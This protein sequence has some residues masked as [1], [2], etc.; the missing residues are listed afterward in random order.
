MDELKSIVSPSQGTQPSVHLISDFIDVDR[1]TKSPHTA[2]PEKATSGS[3]DINNP[4]IKFPDGS[5][6][7]LIKKGTYLSMINN[8]LSETMEFFLADLGTSKTK[9]PVVVSSF[10]DETSLKEGQEYTFEASL[11]QG[12]YN[13]MCE[14]PRKAGIGNPEGILEKT[15]TDS[16]YYVRNSSMRGY[17]YGPP[18]ETV[19]MV[20]ADRHSGVLTGDEWD[21]EN[22]EFK[23]AFVNLGQYED[24]LA[25]NLQDPA[26]HAYTPP[27]F[28]GKSSVVYRVTPTDVTSYTT[29]ELVQKLTNPGADAVNRTFFVDEYTLPASGSNSTHRFIVDEDSL[30]IGVPTTGSAS[31]ASTAKMKINSSVPSNGKLIEVNK[32]IALGP[33]DTNPITITDHIWAIYPEWVCPVLDFSGSI[34]AIRKKIPAV[35]PDNNY[36]LIFN[37]EIDFVDNTFHDKTTGRGMWG[38]YGTDPYDSK[39]VEASLTR[40][41]IAAGDLQAVYKNEKGIYFSIDDFSSTSDTENNQSA[42]STFILDTDDE[43]FATLLDTTTAKDSHSLLNRL[44]LAKTKLPVGKFADSKDISEAI[45]LIPYLDKEISLKTNKQAKYNGGENFDQN[46][47]YQTREIVPG[48]HFLP[49]H[50]RLFENILSLYITEKT[51]GPGGAEALHLYGTINDKFSSDVAKGAVTAEDTVEVYLEH[52]RT[53]ATENT[54]VGRLIDKISAH[55]ENGGYMVPP[56]FD[57]VHNKN[58]APFQMFVIPF[59][60]T[61]DKQDLIDIYQGVMPES[62][63]HIQ[64]DQSSAEADVTFIPTY[65]ELYIPD[66][67]TEFG[68]TGITNF[69]SPS[70]FLDEDIKK[71]EAGGRS[72]APN[73]TKLVLGPQAGTRPSILPYTTSREFYRNLRFMVF[74]V[75]QRSKKDYSNYKLSQ[76]YKAGATKLAELDA[77]N[78]LVTTK[79]EQQMVLYKTPADVYGSNWPYDNF[80]LIESGKIDIE[81]EVN[82]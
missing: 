10:V 6:F 58:V 49:I 71:I 39:L 32:F 70:L 55:S 3:I 48:K 53:E 73:G 30:L 38:G 4:N 35:D 68:A 77:S 82:G 36:N 25:A 45:V 78:T 65:G 13:I 5:D 12:K 66:F 59:N 19:Q 43:K 79:P 80:S 54:D 27:Y 7:S 11:H 63:L 29:Q 16:G 14:G 56:E 1:A 28:Y 62:S 2:Y 72:G 44:G 46:R 69:L 23:H 76:I 47:I 75:K 20:S 42:N 60:E 52:A 57:F 50:E 33:L 41:G 15:G 26:Y 22:F 67:P 34:S 18:L 64:K 37:E 17:I 24:Y 9:L 51:I 74:K 40:N 31:K 61:L 21:N 81:I 8:Y